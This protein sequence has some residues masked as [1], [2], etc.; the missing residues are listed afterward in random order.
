M[1]KGITYPGQ[2]GPAVHFTGV[3]GVYAPGRVVPLESTGHSEDEMRVLIKGTPLKI[4]ALKE[5][6]DAKDGEEA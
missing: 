6:K 4:V 3:P 5:D 1:S 2:K